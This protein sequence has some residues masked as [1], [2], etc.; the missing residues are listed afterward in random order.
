LARKM[1]RTTVVAI[2]P[3]RVRRSTVGMT[4]F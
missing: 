3:L 2:S 4:E 1:E